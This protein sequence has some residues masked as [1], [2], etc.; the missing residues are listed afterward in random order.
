MEDNKPWYMSKTVCGGAIAVLSAIAG[1]CGHSIDAGTQDEIVSLVVAA[2][3]GS[4]AIYGRLAAS[5]KIKH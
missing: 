5:K 1:L 4:V 3:G 2:V